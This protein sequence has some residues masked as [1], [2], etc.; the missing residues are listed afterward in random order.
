[1]GLIW[2][3]RSIMD[4]PIKAIA[5]TMP[6][7]MFFMLT[8]KNLLIIYLTIVIKPTFSPLPPF[9]EIT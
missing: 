9:I 4:S 5:G 1:M 7:M 8:I 6:F 2:A 3:L